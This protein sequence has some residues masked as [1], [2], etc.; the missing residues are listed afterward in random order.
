MSTRQTYTNLDFDAILPNLRRWMQNQDEFKDYNFD[1][2]GLTQL[3]RLLAYNTNQLAFTSNTLFN[4]LHLDTAEQRNNAAS[5]AGLMSYVPGSK[6]AAKMIVDVIVTPNDPSNAASEIVMRRENRFIAVSD[7]TP[8]SFSPAQEYSAVLGV[9]GNYTFSGITLL[10]GTWVANSFDVVGTGI[11]VYEIP[12]MGIDI[13]TLEVAVKPS[14]TI[15]STNIYKRFQTPYDLGGQNPL[16]YLRLNRSGYYEV[17]FGDNQLSKKV[18]DGNIIITRYLVTDGPAD[19]RVRREALAEIEHRVASQACSRRALH[20]CPRRGDVPHPNRRPPSAA[21][22]GS[23][24]DQGMTLGPVRFVIGRAVRSCGRRGLM[25]VSRA[26]GARDDLAKQYR[27][28]FG[29]AVDL[30]LM[31]EFETGASV[32]LPANRALDRSVFAEMQTDEG[33]GIRANR[34]DRA[35]F[36]RRRP[37]RAA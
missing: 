36:S 16:Y 34:P 28:L 25:E 18:E 31:R 27:L 21:V 10:Q 37:R 15:D 13:D 24:P 33:G 26:I 1:G 7:G 9:D 14:A 17:E 8:Y 2:A 6:K 11:D 35:A 4:E 30:R 20:H 19:G 29:R 32:A 23:R 5:V 22:E 3:M 12:S